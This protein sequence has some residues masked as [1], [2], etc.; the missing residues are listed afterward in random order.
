[1]SI[2]KVVQTTGLIISQAV[3][4]LD[5]PEYSAAKT[6][7]NPFPFNPNSCLPING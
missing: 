4:D 5:N 7:L 6:R 2:A 1:V 3:F